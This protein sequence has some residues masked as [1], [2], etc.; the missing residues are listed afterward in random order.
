M[1]TTIDSV[2]LNFNN[3]SLWVLN[4]CLAIIMFGVALNLSLD[5]FRNVLKTPKASLVGV[6]SQ[7]VLLPALTFILIWIVEPQPSIAIGMM[8]VAACPGGNISNFMSHLSRANVALS[9]SLTA[10]S[11]VLAIFMTPLNLKLWASLYPPTAS[12]LHEVRLDNMEVFKAVGIL[13]GVPLILGMTFRQWKPAIAE[14]LSNW[15]KPV[16]ILIFIGFVVIAFSNNLD[17][18]L[19]Y[20]QYIIFIVFIHNGVAFMSGFFFARLAG[21]SLLDQKAIT[22]ETGIQNSGLGLLLIFTFFQGLGGMAIVAAWWGI[23]HIISGLTLSF[24]WSRTKPLV[25]L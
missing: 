23:W 1:N 9:V 24:F 19:E 22:I 7:F 6:V 3:D 10:I 8:M 18:F 15:L 14:R 5:D 16:S 12:L 11:T 21:L 4:F 25:A 13:L 20:F 17:I 2:K